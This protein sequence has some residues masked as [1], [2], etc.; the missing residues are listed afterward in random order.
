MHERPP[1]PPPTEAAA[2]RTVRAAEDAWKT[3]DPARRALADTPERRWPKRNLRAER[4]LNGPV[5]ATLLGLA[6]PN[7]IVMLAQAGANF[8]ESYYVGLLGTDALAG[9]ALVFPLVMLMQ[10][11]S[12]GGIG[13]G[14]SSAIARAIGAAKH[15]EAEAIALHAVILAV[16]LGVVFGAAAI[17][18]GRALYA[19][20]GGTGGALD[21]ALGYSNAIFAGAVFLWLLNAQASILRGTGNMLL[22]ATV[23]TGGVLV[24][25]VVSPLLIFGYGPVPPLGVQGAGLALVVYYVLGST[26]LGIRLLGGGNGLQISFRHRIR[27]RLFRSILGVGGPAVVNNLTV[28]LAVALGTAM[29]ASLGSQ[30]LAGFGLG[31]RLEYLQ[32]PIVFGIG[33]GMVAM[34]GMNVGA[35]QFERARRVALTGA[36]IAAVAT[37]AVGGAAALFPHAWLHLFTR[38]QGAVAVGIR[39]L[40]TVAPAYGFLGFGLAL[41]FASQGAKR[42]RWAMAAGFGRL[43]VVAGLGGLV[44]RG[45]RS[46]TSLTSFLGVLVLALVVYAV[47][48]LV[49]W[50]APNGFGQAPAWATR[51]IRPGLPASPRGRVELG[52]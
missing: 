21:A 35:G 12:A 9:A 24:L 25:L 4:L 28:N 23:L 20:M 26:V 39:Y 43:A 27:A 15:E 3:R 2:C 5:L 11:M 52:R 30:A 32:I 45:S 40:H 47:V 38:D 37:E 31:I 19:A 1:R 17:L 44:M 34:V 48:N 6:A 36:C 22:P 41:Y 8:L 33:T 10:T 51:T 14:I 49:P 13:G 16:V 7:V 29:I 46:D 18:G 50:L 42:M